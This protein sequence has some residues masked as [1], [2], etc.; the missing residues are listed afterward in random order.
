MA[1]VCGLA[2]MLTL[3]AAGQVEG[4]GMNPQADPAA[5]IVEG[6]ARITVL[7]PGLLRLEWAADGK[8][9]DRA[10][11]AFVH[12]RLAAPEFKVDRQ[13]DTT[14]VS[15]ER[16]TLTYRGWGDRF[17]A[18]NLRIEVKGDNGK[19][20]AWR[21]GAADDGNLFGTTRTL[22]GVSGASELEPGLLSRDGWALVDDSQRLVFENGDPPWLTVRPKG[23][24]IDW[25][26]FGHG[27]DYKQALA[28]FRAIAGRTP[29]PPRYVFGTW[30]SR[31]WAYTEAELRE[32]VAD[33]K[34][35]G[36]PLDVLVI[37]MDWHLDGWTGYTWH[38][39]YFPDPA[40]FLAWVREQG[41]RVTLNLHPADGVGPHEA[42]YKDMAAAMGVDPA[43]EKPVPFDCA[44]PKY[45]QAYFKHLHHPL[46]KQG[47]DFWWIDWQQGEE[48]KIAGL[49]PLWWL[50]HLHWQ[51][52]ERNTARGDLR[53]LIFSRWGGLGNH[54]YPIGFSGDTY[55]NW[56][57][58]AFQPYFTATAS[59]VGFGY[60]SHDIGGHQPGPV[61]PELYV[62]WI[63]FG[64]LSPVLRT[65]TTKNPLAERRIWKFSAE[66]FAASKKAFE[67]RYALIPYIYTAARQNYET[68]VSMC[69]PLY[70]EWPDLDAA[71][72]HRDQYMFGDDLMVAPVISPANPA[73]GCGE[74]KVWIPPGSWVEWESGRGHEG[75]R[76]VM[77]QA[78][79]D[80]IPIFVRSGAVIPMM[81]P[82]QR[83]G[84]K[85][86]DPLILHIWA[87]VEG[88]TR[89]YEDDGLSVGYRSDQ[90][91][92][93]PVSWQIKGDD[94]EVTIGPVEGSYKGAFTERSYEIHLRDF[95][96]IGDVLIDGKRLP[97]RDSSADVGWWYDFENVSLVVRT[98]K[99]ACD[100]PFKVEI[101]FEDVVT[102][103]TANWKFLESV[104]GILRRKADVEALLGDAMDAGAGVGK[105][106]AQDIVNDRSPDK[107]RL[108][109]DLVHSALLQWVAKSAV[110]SDRKIKA[111]M[112]LLG[113]ACRIDVQTSEHDGELIAVCACAVTD[114]SLVDWF[115]VTVEL[116]LDAPPQ[117]Q[118]RGES[119]RQFD[120]VIE[121]EIMTLEA[122]LAVPEL[123]QTTVLSGQ[124]RYRQEP[125]EE[126]E[127]L[128]FDVPMHKVLLPSINHWLVAGPF[129][130]PEGKGLST[131]YPPETKIELDAEYKGKDGKA[132]EW[133]RISRDLATDDDLTDEFHVGLF[134][135]FGEPVFDAVAY[136][137]TWLHAPRDMDV[138][139][140]IGSDDGVVAWLNGE[141]VH[142]NDVGR[143]YTPKQDIV[144]IRLREG[145]NQLLLK[146]SQGTGMWSFGA[147]VESKEG[148]PLP[149]VSVRLTP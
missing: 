147:H 102:N 123:V 37:D 58:L 22:D 140:A 132:I 51:D 118:M 71:Y 59:N 68:G 53:P 126:G 47:V 49:D 61:D 39:E 82:A 32:L 27:R 103:A 88:Q 67:L 33:F 117:W 38:P 74:V 72:A 86:S 16:L 5:T 124:L 43:T 112:R 19:V 70:Y 1:Y 7:T 3:A 80:E 94:V 89:V 109:A 141:E 92:W 149:E 133:Q 28:D 14:T 69:R 20:A 127:R 36:V 125:E 134:D 135:V 90:F 45:M 136:A 96:K 101:D 79:L 144:P 122:R 116:R 128:E 10:S 139:L 66:H 9:E 104:R 142:R 25:Y 77:V 62:R 17:S 115:P 4:V 87:G 145:S 131:V 23:D 99:I 30:W 64:A 34:E 42:A 119:T 48:T 26:F 95:W 50:N 54:R 15:T 31:Y 138:Q 107:A 21:P 6:D 146:I 110:D 113:V 93:T 52:M 55:C 76:E 8:F 46:E 83:A 114:V 2:W 100:K 78:A 29:M 57:S 56:R 97:E 143:A 73:S 11:Q 81:P 137:A 60:W 111:L 35:H 105:R 148:E 121:Q 75:P 41:L 91:R 13:G 130:G 12:R 98:P 40:G 106:S 84:E 44:D 18:E 85:A 108:G 24:R 63:Q 129:D 120:G 65:H